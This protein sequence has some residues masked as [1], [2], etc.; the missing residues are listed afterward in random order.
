MIEKRKNHRLR[1]GTAAFLCGGLQGNRFFSPMRQYDD[2]AISNYYRT[3]DAV[4]RQEERILMDIGPIVEMLDQ[5]QG[6]VRQASEWI[7][8]VGRAS[9][10]GGVL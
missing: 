10:D 8:H 4:D 3:T 9:R 7:K 5:L 2:V 1:Q 6:R